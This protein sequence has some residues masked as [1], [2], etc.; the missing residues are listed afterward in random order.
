MRGD[1]TSG[2]ERCAGDDRW[3]E[4]DGHVQI[5]S[6]FVELG[7]GDLGF[8][9]WSVLAAFERKKGKYYYIVLPNINNNP[10]I[11]YNLKWQKYI[12]C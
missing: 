9:F 7:F 1:R 2:E 5:S 3:P 4:D 11:V 6:D 10:C 8:D 12:I